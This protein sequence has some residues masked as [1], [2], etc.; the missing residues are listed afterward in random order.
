[1][2]DSTISPESSTLSLEN[3]DNFLKNN[4][5]SPEKFIIALLTHAVKE[6]NAIVLKYNK[7]K[8]LRSER[9]KRWYQKNKSKVLAKQKLKNELYQKLIQNK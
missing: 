9:N 4:K 3:I 2:N 7:Q 6:Q 5:I 8:K 1:M